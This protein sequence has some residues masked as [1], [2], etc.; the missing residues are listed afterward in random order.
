MRNVLVHFAKARTVIEVFAR[1]MRVCIHVVNQP[2]RRENPILES[3]V[4]VAVGR[5]SSQHAVIDGARQS[6]PLR[7]ISFFV[8]ESVSRHAQAS[9]RDKDM[10]LTVGVGATRLRL[11]EVREKTRLLCYLVSIT[12]ALAFGQIVVEQI[13]APA[14]TVKQMTGGQI[15]VRLVIG[16]T[17]N[18]IGDGSFHITF[19]GVQVFTITL[20]LKGERGFGDAYADLVLSAA[21]L[22]G[23]GRRLFLQRAYILKHLLP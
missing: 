12:S 16:I 20:D 19:G 9:H 18:V 8:V 22:R 3:L 17:P 21:F 11:V 13:I 2:G 1:R 7:R 4:V 15:N 10:I 14:H 6:G 23:S 5:V